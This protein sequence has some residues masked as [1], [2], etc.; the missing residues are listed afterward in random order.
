MDIVNF[1]KISSMGF[2]Y[3]SNFVKDKSLLFHMLDDMVKE[4]GEAN[5]V[6]VVTDTASNYVVDSKKYSRDLQHQCKGKT[7]LIP[8]S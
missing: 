6:Q 4:V 7:P 3:L 8:F 5:V 1:I 2:V